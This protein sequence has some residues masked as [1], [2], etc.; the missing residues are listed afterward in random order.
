MEFP[1]GVAVGASGNAV[2]AGPTSS[3]NFPTT[4][5]AFDTTANG[6][7]DVFVT[8]LNAAG[9]ALI[10]STFLGGSGSDSSG[11]ASAR[12]AGNSYVAGGTSSLDFPTTPGAFDTLPDGSDAFVTKLNPPGPHSSIR[13]FSAAL[14]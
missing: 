14:G 7:F 8:K 6:A 12:S 3:A 11:G 13:H 10:F 4:A 9:S 5:G 1:V 2:V